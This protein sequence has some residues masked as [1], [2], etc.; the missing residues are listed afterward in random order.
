MKKLLR[1]LR[2]ILGVRDTS[3]LPAPDRSVYR[4]GYLQDQQAKYISRLNRQN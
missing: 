1:V 2:W 4:S 3:I